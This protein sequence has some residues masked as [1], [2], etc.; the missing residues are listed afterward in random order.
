M[1]DRCIQWLVVKQY[2][3]GTWGSKQGPLKMR[4]RGQAQPA[5]NGPDVK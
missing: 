3:V 1:K 4:L 2:V 5:C